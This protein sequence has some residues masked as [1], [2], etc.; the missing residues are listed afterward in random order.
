VRRRNGST[1]VKKTGPR[2]RA[3]AIW[4]PANMNTL[5][6]YEI[7]VSR[8]DLVRELAEPAKTEQ[9]KQFCNRWY[10]L[11]GNPAIVEGLV[12]PADWG[13]VAPPSGRATR[14][15]TV[16]SPGTDLAPIDQTPAWCRVVGWQAWHHHVE[17]TKT[18]VDDVD[19]D[20]DAA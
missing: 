4:V 10:L 8:M 15:L 19:F 14:T 9:W 2:R 3:D 13:V 18:W 16:L 11:V 7:K 12:I 6:G 1:R 5:I 20:F 17:A